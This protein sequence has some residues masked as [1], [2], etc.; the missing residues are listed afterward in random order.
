[1]IK[2]GKSLSLA[3]LEQLKAIPGVLPSV[4]ATLMHLDA[5]A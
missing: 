3:F 5:A 1:V 4:E 2:N